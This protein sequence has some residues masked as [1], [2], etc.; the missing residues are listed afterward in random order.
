ML[1]ADPST[2]EIRRFL[3]GPKQSEVT[4][5]FMTPDAQTM[6]VG[7]Q[8]PG[9]RPDDTPGN[10]SNPTEFSSFPGGAGSGRPRSTLIV[11]AKDGGGP[12]GG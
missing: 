6:F 9:E 10:P 1:A 3:V 4:G 2:K 7:I 8:H 11:V 5:V 12:I